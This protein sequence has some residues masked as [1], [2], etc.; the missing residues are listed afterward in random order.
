MS[1]ASVWTRAASSTSC[2]AYSD[3]S[4]PVRAGS[5]VVIAAYVGFEAVRVV[6]RVFESIVDAV[7]LEA[8]TE[9]V[10]T[11]LDVFCNG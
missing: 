3:R 4:R 8:N 2:V 7:N 6:F 1:L 10:G 11:I 9:T 5:F